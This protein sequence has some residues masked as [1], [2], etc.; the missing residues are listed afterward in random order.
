MT[1]AARSSGRVNRNAPF[2]ALPTAVRTAATMT[3][4]RVIGRSRPSGL[5][6]AEQILQRPA[7]L[8]GLSLEEVRR[9]VDHDQFL[10]LLQL[11]V[12]RPHVF[13]RAEFIQF[14]L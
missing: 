2:G 4:A 6:V 9:A 8:S 7:D 1:A 11:R 12:E 13:H 10:G 5:E 3:A 14:A